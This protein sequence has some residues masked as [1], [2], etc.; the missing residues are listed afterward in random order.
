MM[1]SPENCL[2]LYGLV[3]PQSRNIALSPYGPARGKVVWWSSSMN[4]FPTDQFEAFTF[5]PES[6]HR[7]L[8]RLG[9]FPKSA[10]SIKQVQS[11]VRISW[12]CHKS[13]GAGMGD[14]SPR[15]GKRV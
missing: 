4:C 15:M 13:R 9:V 14:L 7:C 10:S 1:R 2:A 5:L 12:G 8:F 11:H 3:S 6:M